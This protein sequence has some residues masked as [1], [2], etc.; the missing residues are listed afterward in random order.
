MAI[1]TLDELMDRL[2]R[3]EPTG[4]PVISL[5]LN[6]EA[7]Q[8]GQANFG[9][10]VRKEVGEQVKTFLKGSAER[11]SFERDAERIGTF[12]EKEVA[13]QANGIAL[14]ACEAAD[15]FEAAQL[16]APIPNNRLFVYE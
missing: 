10:F 8:H 2:A 13:P 14:F 15:L 9:P 7:D 12:L 1:S 16:G 5:Y 11:E 3:F 4:F 6:A